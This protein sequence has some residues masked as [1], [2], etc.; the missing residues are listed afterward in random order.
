ML[1]VRK[2]EGIDKKHFEKRL[3]VK[4]SDV[5]A[6]APNPDFFEDTEDFLIL[7][8]NMIAL[9]NPAILDLWSNIK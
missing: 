7:K 8:E 3:G 6:K 5:F 4:W 2:R 1:G 9:T